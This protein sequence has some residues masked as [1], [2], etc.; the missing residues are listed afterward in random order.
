M[1]CKGGIFAVTA[2]NFANKLNCHLKH[3]LMKLNGCFKLKNKFFIQNQIIHHSIRVL[4]LCNE[5]L[6]IFNA[7]AWWKVATLSSICFINGFLE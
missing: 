4:Y 7:M 5:M 1:K 6:V 3:N 2:D